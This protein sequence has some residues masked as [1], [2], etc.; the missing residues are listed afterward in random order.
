MKRDR[1]CGEC[2]GSDIRMA[3][4]S[5][6][7]GHAPDLLPGAHPWWKSG[8]LEVYV[9]LNCGHFQYFVPLEALQSV[10]ESKRFT[11]VR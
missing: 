1:K 10:R 3:V 9:C 4:V 5:S 8:S 11:Q 6:G 7:G 2:G